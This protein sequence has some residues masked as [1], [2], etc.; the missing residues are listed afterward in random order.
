LREYKLT[1]WAYRKRYQTDTKQSGETYVMVASRLST[2]L[3]YYIAS[4]NVKTFDDIKSLLVADYVK[5]MLSPD[6][7][8][9]ILAVEN[10]EKEG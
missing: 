5:D 3:S 6:C 10:T 7:F 2:M 4:R 1:P 8:Q 9:Q